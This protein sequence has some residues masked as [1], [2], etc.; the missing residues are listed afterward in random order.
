MDNTVNQ[1]MYWHIPFISLPHMTS[2]VLSFP[3]IIYLYTLLGKVTIVKIKEKNSKKP[4]MDGN[5]AE[6]E[7]GQVSE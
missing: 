1:K 5:K 2:R 4:V 7:I 3:L 6:I